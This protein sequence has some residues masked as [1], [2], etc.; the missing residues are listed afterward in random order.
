[1]SLV[2]IVVVDADIHHRDVIVGGNSAEGHVGID[3]DRIGV[4]A[5]FQI[6][7]NGFRVAVGTG[8]AVGVGC[9]IFSAIPSVMT[10]LCSR[11]LASMML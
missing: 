6:G 4:G 10:Q 11:L 2:R 1:M 3:D 9:G 7:N 5:K 8:E